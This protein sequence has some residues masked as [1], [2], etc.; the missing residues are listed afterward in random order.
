MF[1]AKSQRRKGFSTFNI[2]QIGKPPICDNLSCFAALREII[3]IIFILVQVG[4]GA[5]FD[6]VADEYAFIDDLVATGEL[7]KAGEHHTIGGKT[8]RYQHF[9]QKYPVIGGGITLHIGND[10]RPTSLYNSLAEWQE[11]IKPNYSISSDQA[12]QK[13]NQSI[14][15][16]FL[17]GKITADP[18]ILP[19]HGIPVACWRVLIPALDPLG[20]WEVF[21]N[22]ASGETVLI[23]DKLQR[24]NGTG[25]VFDPDPITSTQDSTLEDHNDAAEA[26]PEDA[27]SEV[28]LLS[29]SQD[30]DNLIVLTGPFVDTSPTDRRAR[31]EEPNFR[32]DREDDRF[33]EVMAY[34]H[35]DRQA[36]YIRELGFEDLPPT[37]QSVNVNGI[38]DDVSFFSPGTG[39]ITF[40]SGGVDDA[41]DADVIL[42][43]YSHAL[44]HQIHP[45]WRGGDTGLLTEGLCD[46]LAGDWSLF[47]E[48]EFQPFHVYNWD[49]HNEFW[50]GRILNAN[51]RY[52]IDADRERHDAGQ[53]WSSLLTEIRLESNSRDLWN[54]V[55]IDHLF[56]LGDSSTV[57]QAAEALL[58]SDREIANEQFRQFIVTGCQQRG[59]FQIGDYSP[60][61]SHIPL[62]DTDQPEQNR[63]VSTRIRSDQPLDRSKLYL[64]YRLNGN[65]PDSIL[66]RQHPQIHSQYSANIPGL[67][68][69]AQIDYYIS[70]TDQTGVTSTF[71][72][73]APTRWISYFAGPD[74]VP[75]QIQWFDPI[76]NTVFPNGEI[77]I[78][79][80][81]T[82]N[83]S[84]DEVFLSWQDEQQSGTV[85]LEPSEFNPEL[86]KGRFYWAT[87]LNQTIQ[88]Q[89]KAIDGSE[90]EAVSA[91]SSFE[92]NRSAII[93]DFESENHRWLQNN[94]YRMD[95]D[96]VD[97]SWSMVDRNPQPQYLPRVATLELDEQWDLSFAEQAQLIFYE[98]HQFDRQSGEAGLFEVS[99]DD[100]ENWNTLV[101]LTGLQQ[102][103][104][105]R[106]IN[107]DDY[108]G[109]GASP[110]RIRFQSSTSIDANQMEGWKID[111]VSIIVGNL[112]N[113]D[114]S[115]TPVAT[116][117]YLSKPYPNPV[118]GMLNLQYQLPEVG[119]LEIHDIRGRIVS[120]QQLK[121]GNS[122][123][124]IDMSLFPTG[125]FWIRLSSSQHFQ[126][127]RIVLIK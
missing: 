89:L 121:C 28:D 76:P 101:E 103:W 56:L 46:Y 83:I 48:S 79:A 17:R 115:D 61:I 21:V 84:L 47:T 14:D 50:D 124:S 118:N 68:G 32:F 12:V 67:I 6:T 25:L 7:Q 95:N 104:G 80:N 5:S 63:L 55:V 34:Y 127:R 111:S 87:E 123:V 75:P 86:Y 100:G 74:H 38:A 73:E 42:H 41:E 102:W 54:A 106:S 94:W 82:D 45:R 19:I 3:F 53:L 66:L 105:R 57:P 93:D 2:S 1:R 92:V 97:G 88:Y 29:I 33:E 24:L 126:I 13:A 69:N 51:Y 119:K 43:E 117:F 90:N 77:V 40:G 109:R 8:I 20:D 65:E 27:Y 71:P 85:T 23:E 39:I 52:P 62:G 44:L 120:S 98:T 91:M 114:Y 59:I 110:I 11:I 4:F 58:V 31:L 22:A 18:V 122:G 113:A 64:I 9:F 26:I 107:L 70:A 35:I 125:V 96:A 37:P 108:C 10:N 78:S 30:D 36:R 72:E 99:N 60:I 49:G 16:K 112:V 116:E 81:I 15:L